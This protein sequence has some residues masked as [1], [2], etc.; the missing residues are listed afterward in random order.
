MARHTWKSATMKAETQ[1]RIWYSVNKHWRVPGQELDE[2]ML[3]QRIERCRQ[4]GWTTHFF[5][6]QRKKSRVT[7]QYARKCIKRFLLDPAGVSTLTDW[8]A[9]HPKVLQQRILT[10]TDRE[11]CRTVARNLSK[12]FNLNRSRSWHIVLSWFYSRWGCD[13]KPWVKITRGRD[14]FIKGMGGF[15]L[16]HR[17]LQVFAKHK[18]Y[19]PPEDIT[20]A[21][22]LLRKE[23]SYDLQDDDFMSSQLA[24]AY[25]K[26][27]EYFVRHHNQFMDLALQNTLDELTHRLGTEIRLNGPPQGRVYFYYLPYTLDEEPLH[28]LGRI[29]A[30]R[31]NQKIE[32]D[33]NT[34]YPIPAKI[35]TPVET[36]VGLLRPITTYGE[37]TTVSK[38]LHNCASTY[39]DAMLEGRSLLLAMFDKKATDK[40]IA[41]AEWDPKDKKYRQVVAACNKTANTRIQSAYK[42][43]ANTLL[44]G[45]N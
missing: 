37:L 18:D 33:P 34:A 20:M 2:T 41:L 8:A 14:L 44:T 40:P 23:P 27:P 1:Y 39:H 6:R 13:L 10:P 36:P 9:L 32:I 17:G 35:A 30:I 3:M 5:S 38:R 43:Y 29:R 42:Q 31:V 24:T 4:G 19:Y 21:G 22:Y 11:L 15:D 16:S 7:D 28:L 45:E 26:D 25:E 12:V